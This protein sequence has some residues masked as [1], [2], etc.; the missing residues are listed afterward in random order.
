MQLTP[1]FVQELMALVFTTSE[2]GIQLRLYPQETI[3]FILE[4]GSFSRDAIPGTGEDKFVLAT[5]Q[6]EGFLRM[7]LEMN[8]SPLTFRD[9]L[10]L[11]KTFLESKDRGIGSVNLEMVF[12]GFERNVD[13]FFDMGDM[14][15]VL[16]TDTLHSLLSVL[17]SNTSVS[18]SFD[19]ISEEEVT[20]II[21]YPALL[22]SVLDSIGLAQLFLPTTLP[23]P[24]LESL[25]TNLTSET[26]H[27]ASCLST[28]SI[29]SLVLHRQKCSFGKPPTKHIDPVK[30]SRKRKREVVEIVAEEGGRSR[31]RVMWLKRDPLPSAGSGGLTRRFV[32]TAKSLEV[33]SYSLDKMVV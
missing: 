33:P 22:T 13:K 20:S 3:Q 32:A 14:K 24:L 31:R 5:M 19:S 2:G 4:C 23:L 17:T 10:V 15:C 28:S 9:F 1:I 25:I 30:E 26:E 18:N 29:L 16:S 7:V 6:H 8:P 21:R 27:V 11:I 12:E